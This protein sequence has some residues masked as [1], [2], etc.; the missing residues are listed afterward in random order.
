[1]VLANGARDGAL[2]SEVKYF[3]NQRRQ[4]QPGALQVIVIV[5]QT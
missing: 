3:L 5:H 1:M 4:L 2:S